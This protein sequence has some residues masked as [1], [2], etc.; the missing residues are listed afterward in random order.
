LLTGAE[1]QH[2]QQKLPSADVIVDAIFGTGINRP[3]EGE[4]NAIIKLVNKTV[5]IPVLSIDIPSGLHAD[6]GSVLGDTIN[7]TMTLNF[8]GLNMGLFTGQGPSYSGKTCFDS[9]GV[10]PAIYCHFPPAAR[11]ISLG[12]ESQGLA[13][14]ERTGHKGLYGHLL[15]IGGDQGMSGAVRLAAEAG[16]R[17][18]AGLISIATRTSHSIVLNQTRPELMC[19]AVEDAQSLT[20]LLSAASTVTLGPGLGQNKWGE[21]LFQKAIESQLPMVIDAD[22]LNLL[23]KTP[24]RRDHWVLTPHPGEAARLL[25]CTTAEIQANRF[26]AIQ[27]LQSKYG[28]IT[29]L[30]GAGTLISNGDLPLGLS[31]KGNPGMGS[32]GMGDVLAG[33]IGGLIAQGLPLMEAACLGVTLHGMAGDK[34]AEQDGERGMLAMDLMPHLR[35]LSNLII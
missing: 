4:A 12:N 8:I 21:T 31:S 17:V 32:G 18:G 27:E 19:H 28:G 34:A 2:F 7:A 20:I 35:H 9:L 13:V 14:R 1:I 11:R 15:V 5:D 33:V 22:A 29:V 23:S 3:V 25:N 24:Q 6:N 26:S 10:P 16:A 30:K